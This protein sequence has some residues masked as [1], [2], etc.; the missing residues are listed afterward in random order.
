[1][2]GLIS[3]VMVVGFFLSVLANPH[4]ELCHTFRKC[5]DLARAAKD[6]GDLIIAQT[7]YKKACFMDAAKPLLNLRNNSCRSVTTISGELDGF[8][9]AYAF[10]SKACKEGQD[11]GCFH[12]S[13]LE[14]ERGHLELAMEMMKPLCDKKYIIHKGVHSSGCT[15]YAQMKQVWKVQ[16]PRP[17]RDS[18]IQMPVLAITVFLPLMAVVISFL[19]WHHAGLILSGLAF[20]SYGYYEY[21]VGPYTNIRIDLLVVL[22]VLLVN[23]VAF[24]ANVVVLVKKRPT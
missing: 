3:S 9:S 18:S 4:A 10:F 15:E 19:R 23:L 20:V 6:A 5:D 11:A 24:I 2:K 1:M 14:S 17:A 7:Y 22:P 21:G 12:W 16:N 13:L 8:T